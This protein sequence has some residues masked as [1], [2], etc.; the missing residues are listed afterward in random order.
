M[1]PL[2]HQVSAA[3]IKQIFGFAYHS[4]LFTGVSDQQLILLSVSITTQIPVAGQ[5]EWPGGRGGAGPPS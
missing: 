4:A 3:T 2:P 1:S 5:G